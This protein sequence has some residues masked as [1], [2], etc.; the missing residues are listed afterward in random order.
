MNILA[1]ETSGAVCAVGLL[2]NGNRFLRTEHVQKR[3]NER[4]LPLLEELRDQAGFD[5]K[6]LLDALDVV[7]FGRGPGSFTGVRI[8]AAAA[9]AL[10]LA[11]NGRVL[12][13]SSSEVLA[14][15]ALES[16]SDA[17]GV[18][19]SIRSRRNL[20]FLAAYRNDGGV[21]FRELA[22]VLHEASPE[23]AFYQRH[24]DWL[25]A[26]EAA[27][28]WVG[29]PAVAPSGDAGALLSLGQRY[30]S[31]GGDLD[32][33]EGLPDYPEGEIPWKKNR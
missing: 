15:Q 7:A 28:W 14:M 6:Q 31:L 8:A 32:P 19:T 4:L 21:P 10:A 13:I 26:G 25:L 22:D 24:E 17:A 29:P 23:E 18:L 5:Q 30:F 33:A 9:Q 1:I 16:Q 11:A 2:V 27:P 12:P 20:Y 3:H